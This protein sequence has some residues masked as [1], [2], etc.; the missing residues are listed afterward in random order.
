M[1][2]S[3][4]SLCC[5]Y[6]LNSDEI[7]AQIVTSHCKIIRRRN[8]NG[9]NSVELLLLLIKVPLNAFVANSISLGLHQFEDPL[10]NS[11]K[12]NPPEWPEALLGRRLTS[13][14]TLT[15]SRLRLP[16]HS[17]S[18]QVRRPARELRFVSEGRPAVWLRVVQSREPL[19]P[20]AALSSP[21]EPVAGAQWHQQQVHPPSDHKGGP[22]NALHT[23]H[24]NAPT[25]PVKSLDKPSYA[26]Y[27]FL[28]FQPSKL[29]IDT[30]DITY[31]S[32]ICYYAAK[33]NTFNN[34]KYAFHE[35]WLL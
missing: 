9:V 27:F 28:S 24:M 4:R 25:P 7:V 20:Q 16:P 17:A 14:P 30:E 10:I 1:S 8:L 18:V 19:H 15:P 6:I 12:R 31:M 23:S 26:F 2:P 33:M 35:W 11:L 3:E 22:G 32:K 29:Q 13:A 21:R 5:S 34:S